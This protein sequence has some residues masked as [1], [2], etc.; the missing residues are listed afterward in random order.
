MMQAQQIST[1]DVIQGE[2]T[3]RCRRLE[4]AL[5][6]ASPAAE[7]GT[8]GETEHLVVYEQ[9]HLEEAVANMMRT[10]LDHVRGALERIEDGS[11][12]T[13]TG[14][15]GPIP[16]ERLLAVPATDHCVGCRSNHLA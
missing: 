11:Y 1:T 4:T 6:I 8:H 7:S 15:G 14:C 3:A 10:E 13:C 5:G 2:L 12:G 16:E 9:R